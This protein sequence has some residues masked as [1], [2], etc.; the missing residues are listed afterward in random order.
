MSL[1]VAIII[2]VVLAVALV[3]GL[4]FTMSRPTKLKPHR[5]RGGRPAGRMR[6]RV[7]RDR[8]P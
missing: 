3:G 5:A 1:T 7:R 4:A 8:T 6:W 2:L